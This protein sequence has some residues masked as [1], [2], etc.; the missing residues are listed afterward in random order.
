MTTSLYD[1]YLYPLIWLDEE[2]ARLKS[3]QSIGKKI[4]EIVQNYFQIFEKI[5]LTA[6]GKKGIFFLLFQDSD[7]IFCSDHN[8][9]QDICLSLKNE[10]IC[11]EPS[12]MVEG[13]S[14]LGS[15]WKKAV[16]SI[17]SKK[18]DHVSSPNASRTNVVF[19]SLLTI[20][21]ASIAIQ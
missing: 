7:K 13:N 11:D 17:C 12:D 9:L 18:Q 8:L 20:M 5:K 10:G 16:S 4:T 19:Q 6:T 3:N 14:S 21:I 2:I 15:E 1:R